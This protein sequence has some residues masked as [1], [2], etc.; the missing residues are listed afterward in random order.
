[1]MS[2]NYVILVDID[3]QTYV[4]GHYKDEQMAIDVFEHWAETY[5]NLEFELAELVGPS[6]F[7]IPDEL[8]MARNKVILEFANSLAEITSSERY[9]KT[10]H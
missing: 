5:P 9:K 8:F 3:D 10:L 4:D 6:S 7:P 2:T 1:M